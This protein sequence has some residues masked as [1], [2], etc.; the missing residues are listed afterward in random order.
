MLKNCLKKATILFLSAVQNLDS[1]CDTSNSINWLFV[2]WC[3]D[4]HGIGNK[5]RIDDSISEINS[6]VQYHDKFHSRQLEDFK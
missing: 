6:F 4:S 3:M 5:H 1:P 2:S